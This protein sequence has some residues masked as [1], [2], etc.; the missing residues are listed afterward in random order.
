MRDN[1]NNKPPDQQRKMRAGLV[2][3]L[4]PTLNPL[5]DKV[6]RSRGSLR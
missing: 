1:R 2:N 3:Q 5:F 4:T 6:L